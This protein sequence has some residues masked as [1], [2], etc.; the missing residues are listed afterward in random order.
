MALLREKRIPLLVYKPPH[1][2]GETTFY[3]DKRAA[4]DQFFSELKEMC[5]RDGVA[6]ADLED[7]VDAKLYG[8]GIGNDPDVFHFQAEG[9]RLLGAKIDSILAD[10]TVGK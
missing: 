3:S 5:E 9:H 4:F 7:L 6:Y 1:L 2:P 10:L 8:I